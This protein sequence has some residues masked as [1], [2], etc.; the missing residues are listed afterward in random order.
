MKIEMGQSFSHMKAELQI[1]KV[2]REPLWPAFRLPI[3]DF[4]QLNKEQK[5]TSEYGST[6]NEMKLLSRPI[7]SRLSPIA[8]P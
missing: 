2:E 1:R 5:N 7:S 3:S 8:R 6:L 4:T